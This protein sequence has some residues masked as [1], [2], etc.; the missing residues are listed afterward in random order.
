MRSLNLTD[1]AAY[2]YGGDE[3]LDQVLKQYRGEIVRH[4]NYELAGEVN[5]AASDVYGGVTN[6]AIIGGYG[7]RKEPNEKG[8]DY[9]Y[10][11]SGRKPTNNQTSELWAEFFAAKMTHDENALV[12]I[13]EHFPNAYDAMEKMAQEMAAN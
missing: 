10:W 3:N 6:N 12:S 11:Y 13:K 2:T 9:Q 8:S 7:H 5:E 1:D 4:M